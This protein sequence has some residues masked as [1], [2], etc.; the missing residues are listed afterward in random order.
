[1]L[2]SVIH[3]YGIL[4]LAFSYNTVTLCKSSIA[5]THQARLAIG[6]TGVRE[7][8]C[9]LKISELDAA[10]WA[11]RY[12]CHHN[13]QDYMATEKNCTPDLLEAR[14][15][16]KPKGGRPAK[17]EEEKKKLISVY[18]TDKE[19]EKITEDANGRPL[20]LYIHHQ[21]IYGKVVEPI[22][23]ELAD[24]LKDC[25]GMS[26][27]LNQLTMKF[28][29]AFKDP[30]DRRIQKLIQLT[31]Q[32]EYQSQMIGQILIHIASLCSQR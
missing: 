30:S 7:Q 16:K 12:A 5:V 24:A 2:H 31:P 6:W 26:N 4:L 25:S 10:G 13:N 21:T 20:S 8:V 1:M 11:S 17:A 15:E 14:P 23:K 19:R 27:N 22:P 29:A 9:V 32:L 3:T 18:F 28:N